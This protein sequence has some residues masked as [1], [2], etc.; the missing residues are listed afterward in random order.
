M[1]AWA[2]YFWRYTGFKV[3]ELLKQKLWSR[4]GSEN[5]RKRS[6]Q[7]PEYVVRL[8]GLDSSSIYL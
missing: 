8:C 2:S 1:F 3:N 5:L 6:E 7:S 4:I